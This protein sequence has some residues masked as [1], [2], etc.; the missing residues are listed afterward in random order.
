MKVGLFVDITEDFEGKLRYAKSLGFDFGQLAVWNMELYNDET[1]DEL[2]RLTDELQFT[3]TDLWCGWSAP[4]IWK[5]PDKYGSLGLVPK[6]YRAKRLEE[7]KRGGEF[8]YKLGVKNIITHTGFIPDDPAA[9]AHIGV[10]E[11]LKELCSELGERGQSF[12]FETGE[13]L[14]L[15]L[16]IVINEIGLTNV[17]VNFDPANLISGGRGNPCDAMELLGCRVTGVHAKDAVPPRF[18]DVGGKQVPV[19][20]GRVDF[21]RL[22]C[23]LKEVGYEG[24]I[25]IEHEIYNRPDRDGDILRSREY[26]ERLIEEYC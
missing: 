11:A 10:V 21:R 4:V 23:Q 13:E 25:V 19:G 9:E 1:L 2:K 20:E 7:L 17:G 16:S 12:A 22:L 26:L 8:A 5:H 14:P 18:G 15:T 3:V 6:Q 24:D